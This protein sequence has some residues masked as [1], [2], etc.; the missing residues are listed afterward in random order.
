MSIV[1]FT[2]G[3]FDDIFSLAISVAK[4]LSDSRGS[5]ADCRELIDYLDV[6]VRQSLY[7]RTIFR[8]FD[9]RFE[10]IEDQSAQKY[11]L[12]TGSNSSAQSEAGTDRSSRPRT[13]EDEA[14]YVRRISVNPLVLVHAPTQAAIS[15]HLLNTLA[16]MSPSM[17]A[18]LSMFKEAGLRHSSAS[19]LGPV[20]PFGLD[21]GSPIKFDEEDEELEDLLGPKSSGL[22]HAGEDNRVDEVEYA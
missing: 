20:L 5:S 8:V 2:F 10:E 9:D 19:S 13:T 12:T 6:F 22:F 18:T 15:S 4:A 1:A 16:C 14:Q 11:S 17:M 21:E 3:S 7:C